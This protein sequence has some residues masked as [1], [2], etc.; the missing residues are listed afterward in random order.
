M[1]CREKLT[2]RLLAKALAERYLEDMP[3]LRAQLEANAV[4]LTEV[5]RLVKISKIQMNELKRDV[6]N[7]A[8]LQ[9]KP[10]LTAV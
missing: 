6:Q 3:K 4:A 7:A 10:R 5:E 8:L 9:A 1:D 2:M